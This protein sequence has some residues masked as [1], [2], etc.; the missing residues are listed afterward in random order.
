[1]NGHAINLWAAKENCFALN[2]D[3]LFAYCNA[4]IINR[5]MQLT[6]FGY[7]QASNMLDIRGRQR[8]LTY[9][10]EHA[11]TSGSFE[12]HCNILSFYQLCF[13]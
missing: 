1:M 8:K 3:H 12:Y 2:S 7:R 9:D 10:G 5:R 4:D 6:D 11:G 13:L